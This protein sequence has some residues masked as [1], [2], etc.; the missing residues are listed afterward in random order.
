MR[1]IYKMTR[2]DKRRLA[3]HP[4]RMLFHIA[5]GDA[6]SSVRRFDTLY[7]TT[8]SRVPRDKQSGF[9]DHNARTTVYYEVDDCGVFDCLSDA[10]FVLKTTGRLQQYNQRTI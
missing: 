2:E 5:Y 4:G 6:Y 8:T 7:L 1:T 3:G 10:V 9:V